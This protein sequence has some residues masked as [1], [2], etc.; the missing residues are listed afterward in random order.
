MN[1]PIYGRMAISLHWLTVL[2]LALVF[3]LALWMGSFADGDP[4]QAQVLIY[5]QSVGFL[6]L[7]VVMFRVVWRTGHAAPQLQHVTGLDKLAL[8]VQRTMYGLLLI[9]PIIGWL[10]LSAGGHPV[11]F[12][13]WFSL[14]DLLSRNHALHETLGDVHQFLAYSLLGL[15]GLHVL[16]ALKHH[17]FERDAVLSRMLP[18]MKPRK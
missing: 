18:M 4:H 2:L 1:Q 17:Y 15:I 5:H 7:V 8:G 10:T 11:R 16:A 14:P 6:I 13:A 9:I 12:F 3:P